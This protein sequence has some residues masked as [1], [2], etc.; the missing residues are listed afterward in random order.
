MRDRMKELVSEHAQLRGG[1]HTHAVVAPHGPVSMHTSM[2][3]MLDMGW[4]TKQL[5]TTNAHRSC[6]MPACEHA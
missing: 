2:G 4:Q 3:E 6:H 1:A 5:H